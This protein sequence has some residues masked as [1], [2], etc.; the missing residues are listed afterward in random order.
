MRNMLPVCCLVFIFSVTAVLMAVE[1]FAGELTFPST[2]EEIFRALERNPNLGAGALGAASE[3]D[4]S[5]FGKT[6]IRTR[7]LRAIVEDEAILERAPKAGALILFDT[8]SA[9]IKAESLLLLNKYGRVFEGRLKD[10]VFIV[11][12]HT[13][14]RGTDKYNFMLSQKRAEAVRD[15]LLAE[16]EVGERRLIVKPYGEYKPIDDN[17]TVEGRARNRR[18][19]F[20]RVQ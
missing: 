16:F 13:D 19:E 3:N 10:A 1:V 11:A 20:I 6:Q 14:S 9:R 4:G 17:S 15:F 2:E 18:V 8:N 12:G 7:G 5:L